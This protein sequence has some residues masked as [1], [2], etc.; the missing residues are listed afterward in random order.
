MRH[1]NLSNG[2]ISGFGSPAVISTD[3]G[4]QFELYLWQDL[5]YKLGVKHTRTTAYHPQSNGMVERLHRELKASIMSH[6]SVSTWPTVLPSVILG[7]RT[8]LKVDI[9]FRHRVSIWYY[10]AW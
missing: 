2:W 6:I 9:G 7:I 4:T 3:R 1:F 10:F 5:C 8:T